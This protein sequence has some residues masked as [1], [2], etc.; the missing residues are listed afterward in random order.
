MNRNTQAILVALLLAVPGLGNAEVVFSNLGTPPVYNT[1]IGNYSGNG[2]DGTTTYA[3]ADTFTPTVTT[4]FSTLDIA[5]SCDVT[6]TCPDSF[7]VILSSDIGNGGDS[8]GTVLESFSVAGTSLGPLGSNNALTVLTSVSQPTL[9]SGLQYWIS[10]TAPG[11]DSVVW[12]WNNNNDM[13]DQDVSTDSGATWTTF[14]ANP[15]AYAV[16]GTPSMATVPEPGTAAL[17]GLGGLVVVL[18]RKFRAG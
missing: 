18:R 10:V 17:L 13:S 6:T 15:G 14:D 3:T 7:S 5:L 9:T 4:T 8:P 2:L 12:N 16:N 11:R 1:N